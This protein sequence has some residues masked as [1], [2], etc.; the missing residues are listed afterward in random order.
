MESDKAQKKYCNIF[1]NVCL[2]MWRL[3]ILMYSIKLIYK[4]WDIEKK[5]MNNL[6][7]KA[8]SPIKHSL[9]QERPSPNIKCVIMEYLAFA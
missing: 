4:W 9:E 1:T 5:I 2:V 6:V 3:Q 7:H 8:K